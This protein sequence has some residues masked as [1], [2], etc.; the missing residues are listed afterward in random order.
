VITNTNAASEGNCEISGD[1]GGDIGCEDG[2]SPQNEHQGVGI[3]QVVLMQTPREN[4][5]DERLSHPAPSEGRN[6]DKPL[7][8][9][10]IVALACHF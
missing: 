3:E 8:L 7:G 10:G 9:I 1:N 5:S 2:F 6:Q 4:T